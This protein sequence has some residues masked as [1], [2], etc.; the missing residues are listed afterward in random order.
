MTIFVHVEKYVFHDTS[1]LCIGDLWWT[2]TNK[3]TN[4][5]NCVH[6]GVLTAANFTEVLMPPKAC[7][8]RCVQLKDCKTCLGS[9]GAEGG[10]RECRWSEALKEVI[11]YCIISD[12]LCSFNFT[13]SFITCAMCARSC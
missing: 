8:P 4:N 5:W 3:P 6:K 2:A 7:P 10:W 9:D 1:Q 13:D 12:N 11:T